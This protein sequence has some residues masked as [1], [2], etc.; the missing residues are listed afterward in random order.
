[1]EW[2]GQL[3]ITLISSILTYLA[4]TKKSKDD[5]E[6]VKIEADVEIEKIKEASNKEIEKMKA[7]TEQ[8]IKLKMAEFELKSKS[9]E[10]S[11]KTKYMDSFIGEFME[12]PQQ[13]FKKFQSMQNIANKLPK[14]KNKK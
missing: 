4:A 14:S 13:A 8:Q 12:N 6:K 11:I 7:D 3:A 10:D 2:I 1:M 5:L 9:D